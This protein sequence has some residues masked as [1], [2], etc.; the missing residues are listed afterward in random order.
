MKTIFITISRGSLIRNFFHTGIISGLLNRGWRV[1]VLTPFYQDQD[2]FADYTHPNLFFEPLHI[3]RIR[4][5]GI[6]RELLKGAVFNRTVHFLWRYRLDGI[7]PRQV[8]YIPRMLFLAPLRFIPGF[9]RCIQWVDSIL[10]PQKEH[11]G[12]FVKYRP[13]LV[14]ITSANSYSDSGVTKSAKRFNIPTVGMPKSWD[15]LSKIL[16]NTST[17]YVMVWSEFMRQQAMHYQGYHCAR[18]LVTG[19]PQFDIYSQP[20]YLVSR[21]EFCEQ[22]NF[23]PNKRI[24]LYGSCGGGN[25]IGMEADYPEMIQRWIDDGILSD[26]QILVRSHIGYKDDM[27]KFSRLADCPNVAIDRTDKHDYSLGDYWDPSF[28]HLKHL[29]NSLHH[30]DVCINMG[31]TLTLDATACGTP[32]IN[33]KFDKNPGIPFR[34][35]VRRLYETDY[36][37]EL[38]KMDATWIV[39]SKEAFLT[40]LKAVLEQGEKKDTRNMINR[41]M[42]KND[43]NSAERIITALVSIIRYNKKGHDVRPEHN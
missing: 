34:D 23:D 30:A 28:T 18:V 4:F 43:G 38:I 15:N 29:Y 31:S 7:D 35:S 3:S 8:L 21:E 14:F 33:I 41:F 36:I 39:E 27:E 19:V 20:Q 37:A 42:Y 13:E 16:N 9:R 1:V 10:N 12:L 22:F 2:L 24:V 32:V 11:D 26:M 6:M 25:S 40:A 17:D 5:E